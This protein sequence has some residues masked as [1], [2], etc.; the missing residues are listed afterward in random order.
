MQVSSDKMSD[1]RKVNVFQVQKCSSSR[2]PRWKFGDQVLTR[3]HGQVTPFSSGN[4]SAFDVIGSIVRDIVGDVR[5]LI[6]LP[7]ETPPPVILRPKLP[8]AFIFN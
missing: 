7:L 1:E 2:K 5:L 4:M 6:L 3:Y 8:C